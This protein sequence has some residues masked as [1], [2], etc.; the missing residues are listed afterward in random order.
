MMG[1]LKVYG[2]YSTN[3]NNIVAN[4]KIHQSTLR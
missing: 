2:D 1:V 3:R 4:K